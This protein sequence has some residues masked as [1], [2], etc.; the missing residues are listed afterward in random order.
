[1]VTATL[2]SPRTASPCHALRALALIAVASVLLPTS[3]VAAPLDLDAYGAPVP[4]APPDPVIAHALRQISAQHIRHTIETLVSFRTGNSLSSM[5]KDL[6]EGQ[7][8]SAAADWIESELQRYSADCHGC[9]EVKRDTFTAAVQER[10]PKPTTMTNI[11]AVLRGSDPAQAQRVYLVSGHYDSR[12]SDVLDSHLD[13]PGANDDA[14]GVAVSLECARVLSGLK[15]EATLV[16]VTVAGE[17][18]G[19]VGSHHLA[20]LA[21]DSGWQVAAV[22]NNDIVGG[23]TTPGDRWQDKSRVRVFSEGMPSAATPEQIKLYASVG[24]ESDS[25]SRE[26]ARVVADVGRTYSGVTPELELRPDRF[27]RGGDH[28][29]FNAEGV[30][31]VRFTE[32]RED[33]NHQHQT[34]RVEHGVEYGDL[35]KFVDFQYVAHVATLNA[36]TLATLASAPA[37]PTNVRILVSDQ[38]NDSSLQWQGTADSAARYEVVWRQTSAPQWQRFVAVAQRSATLPL[39]KDNVIFGVRSVDAKGHRSAAVV[40]LPER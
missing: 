22:L 15:P 38:T 34:P 11:Y 6:P 12:A 21:K 31:A 25:P 17:E 26:L 5:D 20:K 39:S 40:P 7:G 35:L 3:S 28:S 32:W 2:T 33:Y 4:A 30:A 14:S 10:I 19:L 29:S 24:Y 1:M 8:I 13:S 27:R 16:F 9:L 37:A 18:Q 23:N 36:A